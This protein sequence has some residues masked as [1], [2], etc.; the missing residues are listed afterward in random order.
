MAPNSYVHYRRFRVSLEPGTM[1]E[2]TPLQCNGSLHWSQLKILPKLRKLFSNGQ[3]MCVRLQLTNGSSWYRECL[4]WVMTTALECS[5]I[6]W[7]S[8]VGCRQP[9]RNK[10]QNRMGFAL[11]TIKAMT[12]KD[13]NNRSMFGVIRLR[14][15][16]QKNIKHPLWALCWDARMF[17]K[18][19]T[20]PP[21]F[22]LLLLF[23]LLFIFHSLFWYEKTQ[24]RCSRV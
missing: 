19:S 4:Q 3:M 20:F 11:D 12:F 18:K 14:E 13:K 5:W 10:R 22:S 6:S 8:A 15:A 7:Y 2:I 16:L 17:F 21:F 9:E 24:F 1:T 23:Y